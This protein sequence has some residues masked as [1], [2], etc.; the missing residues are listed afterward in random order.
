MTDWTPLNKD[1]W[2][3]L[4]EQVKVKDKEGTV[5]NAVF[6]LPYEE[7]ELQAY[8]ISGKFYRGYLTDRFTHWM[9]PKD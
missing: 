2:P 9:K 5:W 3:P 7:Q 8:S 1:N 4:G 6:D